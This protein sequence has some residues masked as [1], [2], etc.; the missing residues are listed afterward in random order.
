MGSYVLIGSQEPSASRDGARLYELAGDLV[1]HGDEVTV[2]LVQNGVF[3]CRPVSAG[4]SLVGELAARATVVADDF[5]LRERAVGTVELVDGVRVGGMDALV[6]AV[7][8][9]GR[10]VVWM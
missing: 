9:D 6:D 3:P 5:S 8:D 1:D 4:A 7:M 2:F 10:K